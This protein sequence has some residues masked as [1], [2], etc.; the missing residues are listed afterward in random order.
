MKI[1]K[2]RY[3]LLVLIIA[4]SVS[5]SAAFLIEWVDVVSYFQKPHKQFVR[6]LNNPGSPVSILEASI[7]DQG[8]AR[9][10]SLSN[11]FHTFTAKVKNNTG[12]KILTYELSW[13]IRHP[14]EN[15]VYYKI[16]A[17]SID[18]LDI[19]Q[20]QILQF[21]R[22][23]YYRDD[24]YYFV[25]ITRVQFADSDEVWEAPKHEASLTSLESIKTQI[26][27]ETNNT[28]K[29]S[30]EGIT[31]DLDPVNGAVLMRLKNILIDK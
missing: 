31:N 16:K 9:F 3:S 23:K 1:N 20:E 15:F 11:V 18:S 24:V 26:N 8:T 4:L 6:I 14:Y 29:P 13:S 25:E 2:L 30:I 21:R 19:G 17:N 22:D 12:R 10:K 28:S 7:Y 5:P 27:S